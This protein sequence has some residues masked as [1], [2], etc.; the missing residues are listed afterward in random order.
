M[1]YLINCNQSYLVC[2]CSKKLLKLFVLQ[3]LLKRIKVVHVKR[4]EQ[5]HQR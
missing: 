5:Y 1:N 2:I 3:T 4:F